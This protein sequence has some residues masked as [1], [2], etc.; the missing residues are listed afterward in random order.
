MLKAMH[1][2]SSIHSTKPI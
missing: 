2:A 1:F